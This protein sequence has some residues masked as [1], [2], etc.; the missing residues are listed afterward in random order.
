M[1]SNA[2]EWVLQNVEKEND[3]YK[4]VFRKEELDEL[5]SK[6]NIKVNII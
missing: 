2:N 6:Q 1:A 5:L 3:I 4:R